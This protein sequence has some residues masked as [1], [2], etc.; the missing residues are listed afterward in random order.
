MSFFPGVRNSGSRHLIRATHVSRYA[1][2]SVVRGG[3]VG[4]GPGGGDELEEPAALFA[5]GCSAPALA[6]SMTAA[7][8]FLSMAL[9]IRSANSRL[10]SLRLG[11]GISPGMVI[12]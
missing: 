12:S 2:V 11:S 9:L 3:A 10:L 8:L 1:L 7:P 5:L 4:G 6:V